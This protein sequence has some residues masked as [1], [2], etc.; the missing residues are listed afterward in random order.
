MYYFCI[1]VWKGSSFSLPQNEKKSHIMGSERMKSV[2]L[3]L[4]FTWGVLYT[5]APLSKLLSM[6][7]IQTKHEW[8]KFD[9]KTDK[10]L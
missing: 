9:K 10:R 3:F 1:A 2:L 7:F 5:R 6:V 8:K 4:S